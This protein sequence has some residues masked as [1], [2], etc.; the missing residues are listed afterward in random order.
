MSQ[1][2]VFEDAVARVEPIGKDAGVG[3]EVID[4]M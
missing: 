2:N 3:P 1:P 4:A